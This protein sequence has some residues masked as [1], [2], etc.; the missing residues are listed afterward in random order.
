MK[1]L[2]YGTGPL[3]VPSLDALHKTPNYDLRAVFTQPDRPAGRGMKL[4][5]SAI[6]QYA[7][8]NNIPIHQP[9]KI[10]HDLELVRSYKPDAV[11]VASYGQILSPELIAI[12]PKGTINIHASLLPK[13][14]G[15]APIQFAIMNGESETGITT[16]FIEKGLD[17]GD[18][19]I[20]KKLPITD[21]DTAGSIHDKLA[22]LGVEAILE[23]LDGIASGQLSGTPQ[24]DELA[25][26]APKITKEMALIDWS[27]DA[28]SIFNKIRGLNPMPGAFTHLNGKRLKVHMS[29]MNE[30]IASGGP[31]EIVDVLD[32]GIV[33]QAGSGSILLTEVQIEGKKRMPAAE[34]ARGHQIN[35]S[36]SLG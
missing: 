18:M 33:I 22:G 9:E 6:K 12:P 1:L 29:K 30:E 5:P 25:S 23:T 28:R 20:M 32:E 11:V 15:A 19:L 31:G 21:E 35:I 10:N 8:D 24:N 34:F 17:T 4:R 2:F 26:H 13:Y 16:F 14:R 27:G 7:L 36:S 3:G